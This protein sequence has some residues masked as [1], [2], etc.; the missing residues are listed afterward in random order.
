[1]ATASSKRGTS[2]TRRARAYAARTDDRV[3]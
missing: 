3:P 2:D 1:M